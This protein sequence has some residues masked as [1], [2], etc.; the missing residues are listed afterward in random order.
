M[1]T[2]NQKNLVSLNEK[3]AS[4]FKDGDLATPPSK[5]YLVG[6]SYRPRK[7]K[8]HIPYSRPINQ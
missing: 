1:A 6:Q 3:Y 5:K 7:R 2:P 4:N 8:P